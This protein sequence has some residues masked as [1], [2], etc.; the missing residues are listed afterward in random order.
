MSALDKAIRTHSPIVPN[1]AVEAKLVVYIQVLLV[2]HYG[3]AC[4]LKG[5]VWLEGLP[6]VGIGAHIWLLHANGRR[7]SGGVR[8]FCLH[9]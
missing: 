4:I 3:L 6:V 1:A 7:A 5:A 9:A 2:V 8:H